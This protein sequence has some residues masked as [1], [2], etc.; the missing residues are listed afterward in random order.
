MSEEDTPDTPEVED[1]P[2]DEMVEQQ[3]GRPR[4]KRMRRSKFYEYGT[5]GAFIAWVSFLVIWLFFFAGNY[6]IFQNIGVAIAS[7][8]IVGGILAIAFIPAGAGPTGSS[9]PIKASVLSFVGWIAFM[10]IWLPFYAPSGIIYQNIVIFMVASL[11]MLLFNIAIWGRT[12]RREMGFRPYASMGIFGGW[13]AFLIIWLWFFALGFTGYQ[14]IAITMV[15]F[16]VGMLFVFLLWRSEIERG[17]G[18]IQGGGLFVVWFLVL[19]AWFWFLADGFD[20]YQN[21]AII[22]VSMFIFTGIAYFLGKKRWGSI[23]DLD[24]DE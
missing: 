14:N 8:F 4:K 21:I 5:F 15:S 16:L 7:F 3:R 19:A 9:W 23:R 18:E 17:K 10:A 24:W 12:M 11:L 2:P 20:V 1:S 22:I 6:D 13:L